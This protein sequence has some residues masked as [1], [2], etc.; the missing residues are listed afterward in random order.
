MEPLITQLTDEGVLLPDGA[1]DMD[2]LNLI[3]GTHTPD[4]AETLW[5]LTG[6]DAD[7]ATRIY[8][9]MTS[10]YSNGKQADLF[11]FITILYGIL[12]LDVPEPITAISS[13][14]EALNRYLFEFLLD[15]DDVIGDIAAS[16]A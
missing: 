7:T 1:V 11:E 2:E 9:F 14:P 12:G 13:H 4:F 16:D 5:T 8:S 3:S 10:L 6:G 15:Y